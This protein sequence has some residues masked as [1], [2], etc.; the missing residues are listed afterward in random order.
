[1][2]INLPTWLTTQAPVKKKNN[3]IINTNLTDFLKCTIDPE[4]L[5]NIIPLFYIEILTPGLT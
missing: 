5:S 4:Q 1:M 2:S 3:K